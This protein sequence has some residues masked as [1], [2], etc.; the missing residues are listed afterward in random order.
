MRM[1]GVKVGEISDVNLYFDKTQEKTRVRI[2][3]FIEKGVEIRENY[4]FTIRGTH[5]L[6]EPHIE[7]T[8]EP[9]NSAVLQ[10]DSTV[11]GVDLV[12]VEALIDRAHDILKNFDSASGSESALSKSMSNIESSSAV[13]KDIL[14]R[15]QNGEGTVGKLFMSDGLYQE[16][17]ALMKDV[18]AHPWK[19]VRKDTSSKRKWYFLYL[20]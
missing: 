4:K 6:S 2:K 10:P 20:F 1:A 13:L 3:L 15:V 5:I 9:G 14:E 7:I 8:P 11:E 18:R 12:P 17:E 19:L 16:M